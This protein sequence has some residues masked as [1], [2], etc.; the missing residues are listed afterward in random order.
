MLPLWARVDLGALTIN[1]HPEFPKAPALQEPFPF[2]IVECHNRTLVEGALPFSKDSVGV[3]GSPNRLG[4]WNLEAKFDSSRMRLWGWPTQLNYDTP[5]SPHILCIRF[6]WDAFMVWSTAS[7]SMDLGRTSIVVV[8]FLSIS[9]YS[10]TQTNW[11]I[12]ILR[13]NS[14]A[15]GCVCEGDQ[16]NWIMILQTHLIF[17][18]YDLSEM[19]LWFGV[20][21]QNPRIWVEL[22]LL[23]FFFFIYFDVF[24]NPNKLGHWNLEAKFDSSRMRLWRWPAKLNYD[25]PNSPHILCVRSSW[26]AFIVWSTVSESTDLGRTYI[27]VF[28]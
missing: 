2:H 28:F 5:N 10:A 14:I 3:F 18:A 8:F 9:M 6:F 17:Y 11:A 1:V 26:G 23:L 12:G 13:Q 24:G 20:R 27:V 7:E 21:P 15:P 25:T 22:P 4:H 19:L 16:L